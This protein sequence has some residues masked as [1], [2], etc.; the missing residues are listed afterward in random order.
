MK[1]HWYL[2]T[3]SAGARIFEQEGILPE[4]HLVHRFENHD[5]RLKTS[6][7]VSDRQGRSDSGG[8][9]G[10]STVGNNDGASTHI[11][12]KFSRELGAYLEQEA[13]KDTFETLVLV[14]EPH[15]L[16]ELK[17]H[18]G[19]VTSPRLLDAVIKDLV[20]VSDHDMASQ[21]QG[22]LCLHEEAR[23]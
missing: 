7:L 12:Q 11:L 1:K 20:H 18:I 8:I 3:Q 19:K 14:A 13:V 9:P 21:L 6:E 2:V 15:F 22:S 23:N 16:G 10:H 17:K 5:G 4:L